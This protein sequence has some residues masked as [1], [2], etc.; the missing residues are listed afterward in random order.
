MRD[1]I[2]GSTMEET[3]EDLPDPA[4]VTPATPFQLP[5]SLK[6]QPTLKSSKLSREATS[7]EFQVWV[8]AFA[9][10]HESLNDTVT[11]SQ[12]LGFLESCLEASGGERTLQGS[13]GDAQHLE[14]DDVLHGSL[15]GDDQ[16]EPSHF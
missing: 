3:C 2:R 9:Q 11:I 15:G 1:T 10:Y 6:I 13:G 12:Q 16:G 8:R 7:S 5:S 4:P 14:E